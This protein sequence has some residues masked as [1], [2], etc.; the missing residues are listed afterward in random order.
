[1]KRAITA[2]A[3][4]LVAVFPAA[5]HAGT[6]TPATWPPCRGDAC[7]RSGGQ[8][9]GVSKTYKYE[10]HGQPATAERSGAAADRGAKAGQPSPYEYTTT[11]GCPGATPGN[12]DGDLSCTSVLTQCADVPDATGPYS[13]VYRR[14]T[15]GAPAAPGGADPS[16]WQ[17][18]GSTCYPE[19]VPAAPGAPPRPRLTIAM[20]R[21]AWAHTPFAKPAI[22]IQPVGNRTLVTLPT[23][24]QVTWP[25]TGNQPDEVRVVTLLGQRV[26]IKPTLKSVTYSFGDGTSATTTSLGGPYP[27]GDVRH[28]YTKKGVVTVSTSA[29]YGGQFRI[30]GSGA[31]ADVPGT[32]PIAG[33]SQTLTVLTAKN[34]LVNR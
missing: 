20:I 4:A 3:V 27:T 12:D 31:W 18:V 26:E 33:P 34:R 1:M 13:Y 16:T 29:T 7:V 25:A 32:L 30:G 17:Y 15:G 23:Y 10:T 11:Y 22:S 8:W 2:C 28:A 9:H 19:G 14:P 24:Y 5:A 21:N 6:P